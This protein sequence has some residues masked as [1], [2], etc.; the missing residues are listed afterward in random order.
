MSTESGPTAA[1][2][3]KLI[4]GI[5][6]AEVKGVFME[7]GVE[8]KVTTQIAQDANV[9][10]ITGLQVEYVLEGET[11]LQMMTKLSESISEGLK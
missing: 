3:A 7:A 4:D 6:L 2:I 9:E 10:V 5:K 11:Y 8:E 1:A